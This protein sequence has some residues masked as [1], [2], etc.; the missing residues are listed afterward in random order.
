[1]KLLIAY[2]SLGKLFHLKDF[3]A[4]LERQGIEVRLVK[5][6]DFSRGFP[7]KKISEWIFGNKKFKKLISEFGPDAIFVDRQ[8]HFALQSIKSGIPTFAV[9]ARAVTGGT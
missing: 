6:V 5:D 7:S 1:M 2:G 4:E 3:A 9:A 8:S